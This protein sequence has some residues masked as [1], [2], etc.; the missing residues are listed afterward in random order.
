MP[1]F[2]PARNTTPP[3]AAEFAAGAFVR[4]FDETDVFV[5][6]ISA[7]NHD[8]MGQW[9]FILH[10]RTVGSGSG[11]NLAH[12]IKQRGAGK[13]VIWTGKVWIPRGFRLTVGF[14]RNTS[15]ATSDAIEIAVVYE[16]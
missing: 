6:L 13:W 11:H 16:K 1:S 5:T 4:E 14:V 15:L 2:I 8:L 7:V 12:H 3:N 9:N 10:P